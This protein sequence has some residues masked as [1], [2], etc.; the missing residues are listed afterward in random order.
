MK[1]FFMHSLD[2]RVRL[3]RIALLA[4][5]LLL[6]A[7]TT[8]IAADESA[9]LS[10]LV[11]TIRQ[12]D[13][14]TVR[15]S[16]MKGMLRGLEGRRNVQAPEG[17]SVLAKE[18][19]RSENA[20]IRES[21]NLL[22]QIFGDAAATERALATLRDSNA[23]VSERQA[24]LGSLVT[25][26]DEG[27]ADELEELLEIDALRLD[28]IRAYGVIA[29]Q[30]APKILLDRYPDATPEAQRATIETLATRKAYAKELVRGI[31]NQV[32]P[33]E[34]IPAYIARSLRDILGKEFTEVYGEIP[35]L[36][37]NTSETIAKYKRLITD[38]ALASADA[39]RGRVVF[40]KTCGA[41]HLMYGTGGKVGPDLTGSNRANLD[42][43]LLNSVNPSG[44]VPEG[45]RTQLIQTVDGRVLTGVLAEEDNQR[46]VLKTV[47]QP[48][49]VIAKEDIET[50]KVSDKSMM[51][52]G[53]LDQLSRKDLFDLVKYMQTKSQVEAAQ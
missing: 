25:Q 31:K 12:T 24:A 50:R 27:L 40:Q 45:Y 48:R 43:F 29:K 7:P 49:V 19:S 35:E 32:V 30:D 22:S 52:E 2:S 34:H 14:D 46:V 11:R 39:G 4:V 47:D 8:A 36:N 20:S 6:T 42:Y 38:D 51:P 17:W 53:Q 3:R 16:L 10:L 21:A 33:R 37:K 23:P 41:C 26:R 28:A 13:Q 5:L 9:T 15:A 44:D 18:L 1:P